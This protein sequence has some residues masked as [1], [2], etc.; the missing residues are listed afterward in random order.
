[1][2]QPRGHFLAGAGLAGQQHRH[3]RLRGAGSLTDDR[4]RRGALLDEVIGGRQRRVR[5]EELLEPRDDRVDRV[6]RAE[7]D[8]VVGAAQHGV[9]CARPA[10]TACPET[11]SQRPR[12][13][14][15]AGSFAA[16]AVDTT[17]GSPS[18]FVA[19]DV[20]VPRAQ[21]FGE[22]SRGGGVPVQRDAAHIRIRTRSQQ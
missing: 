22:R 7:R 17:S 21:T 6:R 9:R 12:S 20:D 15:G 14:R 4:A 18:R 16:V 13:A 3:R 11:H 5:R 1:M 19:I 2:N 10:G 8:H